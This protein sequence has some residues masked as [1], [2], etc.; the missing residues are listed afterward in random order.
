M[1]KDSGKILEIL[2]V[3]TCHEES[4]IGGC[5]ITVIDYL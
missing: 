4:G 3:E 1:S 2:M 5:L